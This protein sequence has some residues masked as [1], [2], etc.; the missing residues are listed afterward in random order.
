MKILFIHNSYSDKTPTGEEHASRELAS[1]LEA[2]G[3]TVRWFM[4]SSDEIRSGIGQ[5]KAFVAGIYNPAS[6]KA[7]AKV[8]DEYR[9]DIVQV[10]NLYPLISTSIFKPLK[11][12]RIPVV[13]RC[14]NYRLFCPNGLCLDTKGQVCEKCWGKG[15]ER[16]CVKGNCESGFF[17]SLGYAVR[18]AYARKTHNILNG[19]DVFIVQSEFQK[20]KFVG[21]GIPEGSIGI[22]PGIS[23]DV[24]QPE[25][26]MIGDWVSFV[27]RVSSE[28]GIQEF[29]EA[30]RLNPAMPFK[31][32][33]SLDAAFVMPADLPSNIEF[34][35][36]LKGDALNEFY[37]NSRI[38]VVPSKWYEGFPNVILRG[39]MLGRPIITT[40]IGAMQSIVETG[41]DGIL[42]EPGSV[43]DLSNAI[44]DL[45]PEVELCKQ[46]GAA[47]R[48]KAETLYSREHIYEE[49]IGIY[50]QAKEN[51][52]A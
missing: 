7:L 15:H 25:N 39:F 9:P 13:M 49:L 50:N 45:Y 30:A 52:K 4:R 19:V 43:D 5:V 48:M 31:V 35:G 44:A 40:N 42:V 46:Y 1:L 26:D 8:L 47:G 10:Q 12:R 18:N 36:F 22:L 41:K 23:P 3:H 51:K 17:K 34:F 33:G 38:I 28:K 2:H 11:K 37:L 14:P 21:Q 27:G 16:W 29:I 20:R 6:A 24:K 32:A